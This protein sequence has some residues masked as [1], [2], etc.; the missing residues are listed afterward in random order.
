M[1]RGRATAATTLPL[2]EAKNG[3]GSTVSVSKNGGEE[4]N[5]IA[6]LIDAVMQ[7]VAGEPR[8]AEA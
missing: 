5:V 8:S 1:R 2:N 6:K 3:G 7:E 4:A